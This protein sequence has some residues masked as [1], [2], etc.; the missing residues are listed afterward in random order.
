[1]DT[2]GQQQGAA[3]SGVEGDVG[4]YHVTLNGG[5]L[6]LDREI[7]EQQAWSVLAIV[8]GQQ[9]A[10]RPTDLPR[11][12]HKTIQGTEKDQGDGRDDQ[13]PPT[14]PNIKLSVGEFLRKCQAKRNPDKITAIGVYLLD[15]MAFSTFT[16][17]DVKQQFQKA[18]ES[19]P[20]NYSRDFTIAVASK[21]LSEDIDGTGYYVTQT[22]RTA[23]DQRFPAE[24]RKTFSSAASRKRKA[25]KK[26]TNGE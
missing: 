6:A 16:R 26:T 14:E 2:D 25:T 13:R 15:Q 24:S 5:G 17:D 18:G 1:M 9:I 20:G 8:F 10:E 7:N 12:E 22:G 23:V 3:A 4:S 11:Q 21:W 19:I